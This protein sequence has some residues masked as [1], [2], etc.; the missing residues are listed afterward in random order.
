MS[1]KIGMAVV[2]GGLTPYVQAGDIGIYKS[3]KDK[4]SGY[5]DAWKSSD[6]VSYTRNGNPRPPA[7]EEVTGWVQQ[8]WRDVPEDVV[9]ASL[10]AAGFDPDWS[11]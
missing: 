8:A 10:W 2:P 9:L 7:I 4:M 11:Q 6:R 3:F 5:I 1:K